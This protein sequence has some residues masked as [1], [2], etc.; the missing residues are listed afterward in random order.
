MSQSYKQG[1]KNEEIDS[2]Y[3]ERVQRMEFWKAFMLALGYAELAK[4][5]FADIFK[6]SSPTIHTNSNSA[7]FLTKANTSLYRVTPKGTKLGNTVDISTDQKPVFVYDHLEMSFAVKPKSA[8]EQ[9]EILT[10]SNIE[11]SY[12]DEDR[13]LAEMALLE[14]AKAALI[15]ANTAHLLG[16]THV[17]FPDTD[18]KIE[19]FFL[20]QACKK[21]GLKYDAEDVNPKD[22]PA[23]VIL[24]DEKKKDM[25][26]VCNGCFN[27]I[28]AA[29]NQRIMLEDKEPTEQ[30]VAEV[31]KDFLDD[32]SDVFDDAPAPSPKVA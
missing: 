29:P 15:L 18:D 1:F 21:A 14:R 24:F 16:W 6:K 26:A 28:M 11:N 25:E 8:S 17:K 4:A 19:I 23:N 30:V 12:M 22:F 13:G 5:D 20:Q 3:L 32:L 9:Y 31:N 27:T 2:L 7:V 10:V